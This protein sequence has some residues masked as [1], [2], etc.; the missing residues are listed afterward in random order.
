[1]KSYLKT[2]VISA[3]AV[4]AAFSAVTYSACTADSDKCKTVVCANG[5]AC[6]QGVCICLA[7]YQGTLCEATLRTSY[8]T[9]D[10]SAVWSILESGTLSATAQYNVTLKN[11]NEGV[12]YV[13]IYNF[14][15]SFADA[16]R[17]YVVKDSLI[18]PQQIV[19]KKQVQG[20]GILSENLYYSEH[21]AILFFYK[22][23]DTA[24]GRTDEFGL[25]S[26]D[27]SYWNR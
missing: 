4:F 9:K 18:I 27:P 10:G 24:T 7:G 19:D 22:V 21:G 11:S 12:N 17:A 25:D 16:V 14:R 23:T 1:M 15:N 5:G 8:T 20:Y 13:L 2:I 3:L 6:S 26:G